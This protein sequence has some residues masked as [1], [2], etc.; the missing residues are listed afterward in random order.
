MYINEGG[1]I[2]LE[3]LSSYYGFDGFHVDISEH[4][5]VRLHK[6]RIAPDTSHTNLIR[7]WNSLMHRTRLDKSHLIQIYDALRLD[8]F[9]DIKYRMT[10]SQCHYSR[11]S[12]FVWTE[13]STLPVLVGKILIE[14]IEW[15]V[16]WD[17]FSMPFSMCS[18]SFIIHNLSVIQEHSLHIAPRDH[19][20]S[21]YYAKTQHMVY[22]WFAQASR[23]SLS[24][25]QNVRGLDRRMHD[26][27]YVGGWCS[28]KR[29]WAIY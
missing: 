12:V 22:S 7:D 20:S 2:V 29:N 11:G 17:D 24:S 21:K 15:E 14:P 3:E 26:L 18:G 16:T 9:M 8:C 5:A 19:G 6:S 25:S 1:R 10:Y 4:S 28:I 27:K 23:L 13:E